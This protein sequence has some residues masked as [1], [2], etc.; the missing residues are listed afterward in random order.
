MLHMSNAKKADKVTTMPDILK[1]YIEMGIIAEDNVRTMSTK[2][3]NAKISEKLAQ[4]IYQKKK[5][6]TST[7]A[8]VEIPGMA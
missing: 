4:M 7:N 6:V 8:T 1:R 3:L 5:P 2:D